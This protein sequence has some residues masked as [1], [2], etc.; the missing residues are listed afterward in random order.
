MWLKIG[1]VGNWK[2]MFLTICLDDSKT[3]I[4]RQFYEKLGI[5]FTPE[6]HGTKGL[7]HE[8]VSLP[9]TVFE[10]YPTLKSLPPSD[11]LFLGFEVD[12]P[13]KMKTTLLEEFGG[14]EDEVGLPMTASGI[15][16]LRD[17]NGILVRLFPAISS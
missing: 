17:P 10:I 12:F 8:S 1:C 2:G 11:R 14:F 13:E 7:A 15:A 5:Q 4:T 16:T 3:T 6:R 9:S